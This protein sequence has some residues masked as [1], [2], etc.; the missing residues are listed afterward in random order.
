[1]ISQ[2]IA[3]G[4]YFLFML[5]EQEKYTHSLS[6]TALAENVTFTEREMTFN[7][8]GSKRLGF[9]NL[10]K[11]KCSTQCKSFIVQPH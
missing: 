9:T 5:V 7:T 8:C 2:M 3:R 4:I 11:F 10:L 6:V 1:M